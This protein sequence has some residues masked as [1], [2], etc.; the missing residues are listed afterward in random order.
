MPINKVTDKNGKPVKKDGK[1]KYRVRVAYQDKNGKT[2]QIERT[3]YGMDEAKL[4]EREL[5]HQLK[6]SSP[7]AKM[8]LKDLYDEY[9]NA[10]KYEIRE[11]SLQKN[12]QIL[13]LHVIPK[14]EKTTLDKLSVSALQKWKQDINE[15]DYQIRTKQNFYK[16]FRALLNYAVQMEYL[17]KNPL[18]KVGNFKAP[19]EKIKEMGFYTP[20]EFRMFIDVAQSEAEKSD[21]LQGWNLFVFFYIAFFTGMRKGEINAL[22]WHDVQ[23]GEIKITK[24]VAQKLKGGDRITPPKNS[25]SVR[26]IQIPIPLQNVLDKHYSLCR[27]L[28]GFSDDYFV[29]GGIRPLRDTSIE[30]ANK[31]YAEKAGIKKIRIHDFRH[32][33]ASLLANEG[34]NIQEIARRLGHSDVSITLKTYSHLYPKESERALTILNKIIPPDSDKS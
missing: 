1:Q 19:L 15:G 9:I 18:L 8:T 27:T 26:V 20:E 12:K 16:T 6:E 11:T 4:I 28:Q 17:P 34:I 30:N 10:K 23:N 2:K 31:A 7:A 22:T 24:S 25:S 5:E 13:E 14:F 32:S 33:H 21:S 3:A 29:C